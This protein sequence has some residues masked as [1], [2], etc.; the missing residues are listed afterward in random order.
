M[1]ISPLGRSSCF[2]SFDFFA[3]K[4]F[5]PT[6][7]IPRWSRRTHIQASPVA[8]PRHK[9]SDRCGHQRRTAPCQT[10]SQEV[11]RFPKPPSLPAPVPRR[12]AQPV[13]PLTAYTLP[14]RDAPH[15]HHQ[16]AQ[17]RN[18]SPRPQQQGLPQ[19]LELQPRPHHPQGHLEQG[20]GRK[21]ARRRG[22]ARI[23]LEQGR[24]GGGL[25]KWR[26][27]LQEMGGLP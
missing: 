20:G 27:S 2:Q 11:S 5:R 3:S 1:H 22:K 7:Q 4:R 18:P 15:R 10:L 12:A 16:L 25:A 23:P 9:R 21:T 14:L 13:S 24:Q 8:H 6:D 26:P 19:A 17:S